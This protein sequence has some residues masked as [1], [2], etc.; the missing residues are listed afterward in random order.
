MD[1]TTTEPSLTVGDTSGL[2]AD[3]GF[4]NDLVIERSTNQVTDLF[5]G[6]TLSL[7]QAEPGT[8]IKI[9]VEQDLSQA[10]TAVADF[11]TAYNAVRRLI[12]EHSQADPTTGAKGPE[13]GVLF[14]DSTLGDLRA[15]L[16]N[17]VGSGVAGVDGAFSVLAQVGVK[18]VDNASLADAL[19][20]NTLRIDDTRLN[21]A[22]VNNADDVRRLFAFDFASSSSSV[23]M[24]DYGANTTFQLGGYTLNIGTIGQKNK[25]SAAVVDADALLN[26]PDSFAATTSGSFNVNGVAVVYD[27]AT[28]SL[29]NIADRINASV[30]P[31]VVAT[32]KTGPGGPFLALSSANGPLTVDGDTGDLVALMDIQPDTSII[33]SANIGGTADGADD[34]SVVIN[35]RTL[36]VTDAGGATGLKLFYA[37]EAG[38]SG[39]GIDVTQGLAA[40]LFFDV[41]SFVSLTD[42]A[43]Q[44]AIAAL[45]GENV[46]AERRIDEIDARLDIQRDSLTR[47]FVAME[48]ALQSLARI[49]EQLEQYAA[50]LS[51]T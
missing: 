18:F 2:L 46:V 35:G 1:V 40:D 11:V 3:L 14:A 30:I 8:S 48:V 7:F 22:L 24:L 49:R 27:V 6:V 44:S 9:E 37:G 41:D 29:R 12:N 47:R 13:S 28:E 36:T 38:V 23:S 51:G 26:S 32:V 33:D 20:K 39:I 42:G 15:R 25:N 50:Q 10:K 4:D 5:A 45:E 16:A 31:G 21:D 19:D 17:A 43:L 34:G